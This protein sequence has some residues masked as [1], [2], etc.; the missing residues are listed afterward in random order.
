MTSRA[1]LIT[2]CSTGIGRAAAERLA[3][4]GW[5]VYA[6]ARRLESIKDLGDAGCNLLE[7]DVCDE[8]SM[9]AAVAEVEAREG[10]VFAL[11]NNAGYG[12]EGAVEEVPM[13]D[14]RR[15]FETNVFG[16]S[17]LT[18]LALPGMRKQGAGRIVNVSS[19]GG[20]ITI[21]GGGYYHATKHAVEAIS[22]TLR[23]EIRRFGVHVSVIEPG[24][25]KTAFGDTAT[26]SVGHLQDPD[27]PYASFNQV[28]VQKINDA[29]EGKLARFAAP[30]EAVAKVIDKAI[31]SR[32]PR[33]RY[34]VTVAARVMLATRK[35]M[36][37]RGWDLFLRTQFPSKAK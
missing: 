22:D 23:F 27:S 15:V 5:P 4:K 3:A 7:L 31:S 14:I 1:V 20:K 34:R 35:V 8:E 30:P 11:V 18:Q 37:D 26:K 13:E 32:T 24:T 10:A 21:P 2:G 19:M 28:L 17:R 9:T 33:T 12:Q 29:Y 25:I 6:T 16:L 36:P